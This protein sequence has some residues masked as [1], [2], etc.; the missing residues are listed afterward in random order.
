MVLSDGILRAAQKFAERDTDRSERLGGVEPCLAIDTALYSGLQHNLDYNFTFLTETSPVCLAWVKG[1]HDAVVAAYREVMAY[2]QF[3][4][5]DMSSA[6]MEL[7]RNH[8]AVY[9]AFRDRFTQPIH[10]EWATQ[11]NF[12]T[13]ALHVIK[14]RVEEKAAPTLEDILEASC[15]S[16][17][18]KAFSETYS[19][20]DTT[21]LKGPDNTDL[22]NWKSLYSMSMNRQRMPKEKVQAEEQKEW[23]A[24]LVMIICGTEHSMGHCV[25]FDCAIRSPPLFST[26][27]VMYAKEKFEVIFRDIRSLSPE[28]DR[29][30]RAITSAPGNQFL[31]MSKKIYTMTELAAADW[32]NVHPHIAAQAHGER[33]DQNNQIIEHLELM[34]SHLQRMAYRPA[35]SMPPVPEQARSTTSSRAQSSAATPTYTASMLDEDEWETRSVGSWNMASQNLATTRGIDQVAAAVA[36]LSQEMQSS[37]NHRLEKGGKGKSKGK[38]PVGQLSVQFTPDLPQV[39]DG[40]PKPPQVYDGNPIGYMM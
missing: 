3:T 6:E 11:R 40:N 9:K 7:V 21:P 5:P 4:G 24:R 17:C 37:L 27:E 2:C 39:W 1:T 12:M 30:I 13:M 22:F 31:S 38:T 10:W 36:N 29:K 28:H 34:V 32:L 20:Y 8:P 35:A 25:V 19:S 33:T 26:L 23:I 15:S 14:K 16:K 18:L